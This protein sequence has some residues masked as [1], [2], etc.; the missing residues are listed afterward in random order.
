MLEIL[1]LRSNPATKATSEAAGFNDTVDQIMCLHE[2]QKRA[3]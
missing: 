3:G 1:H 2:K